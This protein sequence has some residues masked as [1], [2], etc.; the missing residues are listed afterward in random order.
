MNIWLCLSWWYRYFTLKLKEHY[1]QIKNTEKINNE[2]YKQIENID[3]F[4][5]DI[6]NLYFQN[7]HFL[8]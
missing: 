5:K 7:Q 8:Y 6:Q 1:S 2:N 4:E 3:E